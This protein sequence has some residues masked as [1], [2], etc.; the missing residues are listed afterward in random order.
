MH[1]AENALVGPDTAVV[2]AHGGQGAVATLSTI[3]T[4]HF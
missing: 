3:E 2:V 4:L 1:L